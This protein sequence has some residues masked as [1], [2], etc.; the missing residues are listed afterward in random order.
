MTGFSVPIQPLKLIKG[1][2]IEEA[3]WTIII[4]SNG[5]RN[6]FTQLQQ[7]QSSL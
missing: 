7:L 6:R 5:I 1:T 2:S 4:D 3:P